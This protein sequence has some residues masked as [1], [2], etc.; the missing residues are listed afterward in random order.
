MGMTLAKMPNS[1]EI[2]PEQNTFSRYTWPPVEGWSHP[3]IS[4]FFNPE[5]SKLHHTTSLEKHITKPQ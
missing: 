4:K 2:E 1:R 5:L 3:L